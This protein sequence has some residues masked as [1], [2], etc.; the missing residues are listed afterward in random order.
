MK[1]TIGS[2][3]RFAPI[4]TLLLLAAS[5]PANGAIHTLRPAQILLEESV[6]SPNLECTRDAS[7][8]HENIDRDRDGEI[9]PE[10]AVGT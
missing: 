4:S 1:T 8:F 5:D 3:H 6:R 9:A 2:A 7:T 10:V